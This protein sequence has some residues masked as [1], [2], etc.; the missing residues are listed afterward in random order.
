MLLL[1]F[2]WAENIS[3]IRPT[4]HLTLQHP[5]PACISLF[6]WNELRRSV[7][8]L[9]C[10]IFR[11]HREETPERVRHSSGSPSCWGTPWTRRCTPSGPP[12]WT[13]QIFWLFPQ[14]LTGNNT[15]NVNG[16]FIILILSWE[17]NIILMLVLFLRI[18]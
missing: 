4:S 11:K 6:S 10:Q 18:T 3:C 15:L 16:L 1:Q 5:L 14:N 2:K 17:T 7:P 9:P 8:T 12:R 13:E